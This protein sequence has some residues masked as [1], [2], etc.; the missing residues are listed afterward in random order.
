[1]LYVL[2]LTQG[3]WRCYDGRGKVKR[4]GTGAICFFAG[5]SETLV[6]L[7]FASMVCGLVTVERGIIIAQQVRFNALRAVGIQ[8]D[9]TSF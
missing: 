1:V 6:A 2:R 3:A 7:F 5:R 8:L 9:A 4:H